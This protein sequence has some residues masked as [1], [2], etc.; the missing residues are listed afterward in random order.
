VRSWR[1]KQ[2]QNNNKTTFFENKHQCDFQI[3]AK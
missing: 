1:D 2:Q 3:S